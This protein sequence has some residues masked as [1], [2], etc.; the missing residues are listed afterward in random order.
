M[1]VTPHIIVIGGGVIGT[2]IAW[3][4]SRQNARVTLVEQG[5]LASGSSGACDGLVF[6]QS[7]KPGIHLE[8][9]MASLD[10]FKTLQKALPLDVEFRQCGGLVVI[11]SEAEFRA[12]EKFAKA[13]QENGLDVRLLDRDQAL[14]KEPGLSRTILGATYSPL[15]GQVNPI[16]LT[17]SFALAA[18]QNRARLLTHTRVQALLTSGNRVTGV[19]TSKGKIQGD[20]VVNA[21]GSM[22]GIIG[23]MA[24]RPFPIRPRQG[25]IIVTRAAR[26]LMSHSLISAKYIAAKFDPA[27]ARTAGEGISMEQAENGNL[28]LGSTREFRGFDKTTTI[29]ALKKILAHTSALLPAVKDLEIIRSFAG[30][31]PWTP[32]GMPLLGEVADLEGLIMAAG[33]E[34]DG[35]ALSPITGEI[36]AHHILG[37]TP[38]FPLD[39][40][41]PNR[42]N[43]EVA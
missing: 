27:L 1:S 17:L 43:K 32:D 41:S 23:D 40:F 31:R 11:E 24:D 2:S 37:Q 14:E 9:A 26:P 39:A 35:I 34:G 16:R 28:L 33:H 36:M 19:A 13:Q 12:M 10:R 5:D 29:K 21:A 22:G 4:L 30:L 38:R 42:F 15:D 3:H 18:R 25:Q 7:K 6:M 20:I 8:L